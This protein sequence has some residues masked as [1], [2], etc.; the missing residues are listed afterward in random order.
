MI[1]VKILLV[2]LQDM[3]MRMVIVIL[4][5]GNLVFTQY[6]KQEDGYLKTVRKLLV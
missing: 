4:K 2:A 5:F 6:D 3:P 1:T